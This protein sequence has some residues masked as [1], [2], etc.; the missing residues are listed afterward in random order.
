MAGGALSE[1]GECICPK[2]GFLFPVRALSKVFRG[3][4][5]AGLDDLRQQGICLTSSIRLL[6]KL[7]SK[8]FTPT[9]GWS[10][11]SNRSAG[12]K[13]LSALW[14]AVTATLLPQRAGQRPE[15]R[16]ETG[17]PSIAASFSCGWARPVGGSGSFWWGNE[18]FPA[19][20]C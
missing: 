1:S 15:D 8:T 20:V 17:F 13:P 4:F 11:P 9:T 19:R 14:R 6:G 10:M 16:H 2:K 18:H 3:K 12:R 5:I 7:S